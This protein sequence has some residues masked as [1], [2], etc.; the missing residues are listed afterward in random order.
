MYSRAPSVLIALSC[1]TA[2]V[3]AQQAWQ[4]SS[5]T[6]QVRHGQSFLTWPEVGG[7]QAPDSYAVYASDQAIQTSQDLARA[8][9]LG[10]VARGSYWSQRAGAPWVLESGSSQ[11]G[12]P[13]AAGTGFFVSTHRKLGNRWYAVMARRGL[14]QNTW[15]GANVSQNV[16][17]KPQ[18][19][20]PILQSI[21]KGGQEWHYAHFCAEGATPLDPAMTNVEGKGFQYRIVMDPTTKGPRPLVFVLHSRGRSFL[22]F[23]AI[24]WLPKNAVQVLV[25]DDETFPIHSMWF[26]YHEGFGKGG[27][28]AG[29]VGDY[30]EQRILWTLDQVLPDPRLQIDQGRVYAIGASLGAIAAVGLGLRHSDRF[31]AVGGVDPAF[32]VLHADF[33]LKAEVSALFGTPSQNLFTSYGPRVYD[34]FD[35]A[36][37]YGELGVAGCA[38]MLFTFGRA[39]VVTGWDDKVP[40]V[41]AAQKARLPISFYWDTR[42]HAFAGQWTGIEDKLFD[43]L[44]E[45]RL[46]RPRVAFTGL[47]LDDDIGTGNRFNGAL[48]GCI[49]GYIQWDASSLQESAT[50]LSFDFSLKSDQSRLDVAPAKLGL[51]DLDLRDLGTFAV[52]K[53]GLYEARMSDAKGSLLEQRFVQASR[54]GHL[55]IDEIEVDQAGRKLQIKAYQ[56]T[57]PSLEMG[58]SGRLKGKIRVGLFAKP[59]QLSL[60]FIGSQQ[61]ALQT[62]LGLWQIGD[63]YLIWTGQTGSDPLELA[64][65][66]PGNPQL[67][68]SRLL[69]QALVGNRVTQLASIRFRN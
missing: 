30:T 35:Y 67:V 18:P 7:T 5:L 16:L 2:L 24:S 10:V 9:L 1:L 58:G 48:V 52:Q 53:G 54:A 56:P 26:G 17:E 15:L 40:F 37:R 32:G 33:A 6:V 64:F 47:D 4:V 34:E 39:D 57:L 14:T 41:T 46:D 23:P 27:Q 20:R 44:F 25:D 63:P 28:P 3:G 61:V 38:P 11:P 8:T 65:S 45:I 36:K 69:A 50:S 29:K 51:V 62:S 66:V 22:A 68:G 55:S 13:L 43:E 59:S 19:T 60:I 49:G 31:A 12:Q 42:A 21:V